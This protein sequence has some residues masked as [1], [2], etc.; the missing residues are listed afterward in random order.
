MKFVLWIIV[1]G[2]ALLALRFVNVTAARRRNASA[3]GGAQ[4]GASADSMVR[5]VRCGVY[6]PSTD[7]RPGPDGPTCGEPVCLQRR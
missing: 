1:I 5:C 2:V 7:A 6:V 4:R 3:R